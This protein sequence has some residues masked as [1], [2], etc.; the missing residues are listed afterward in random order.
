MKDF[1]KLLNDI[2]IELESKKKKVPPFSHT[3]LREI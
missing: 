1:A 2:D 3:I